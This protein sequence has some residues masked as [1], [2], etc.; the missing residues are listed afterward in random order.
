MDQINTHEMPAHRM[1]RLWKFNIS[2]VDAWVESG[3]AAEPG[4]TSPGGTQ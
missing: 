1:S 3:G 2:Q 4:N